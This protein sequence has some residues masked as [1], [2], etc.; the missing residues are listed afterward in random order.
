ME[1]DATLT[2]MVTVISTGAVIVGALFAFGVF[3]IRRMDAA[4]RETRTEFQGLR[5]E[6]QGVRNEIQGLRTEMSTEFQNVRTE[7]QGVR[8]EIQGVR[9]DLGPR[10]DRVNTRVD[11][12]IELSIRPDSEQAIAA[13]R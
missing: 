1:G 12:V 9:T 8:N 5:T 13:D 2:M 7:I 11:R 3:F 6:I 4:N 10:I